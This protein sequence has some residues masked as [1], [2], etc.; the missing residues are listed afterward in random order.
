MPLLQRI[1]SIAILC[2][3]SLAW[4]GQPFQEK[5][6]EVTVPGELIVQMK[7]GG[8]INAVIASVLPGASAHALGKLNLHVLTI[9]PGR[10]KD[11]STTLL[12]ASPLV[13]YVQPNYIRQASLQSPNDPNLGSHWALQT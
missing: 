5:P 6:G 1:L 8:D 10:A 11:L 13:E 12:A 4:A 9:P 2:C 7:A 3:L